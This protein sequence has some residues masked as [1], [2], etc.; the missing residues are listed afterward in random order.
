MISVTSVLERSTSCSC[1]QRRS[2]AA[3]PIH[4]SLE[5]SEVSGLKEAALWQAPRQIGRIVLGLSQV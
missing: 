4:V 2:Q 5:A 3:D 1:R